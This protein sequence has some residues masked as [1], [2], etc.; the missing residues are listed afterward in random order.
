[1]N[2]NTNH[3]TSQN[4]MKKKTPRNARQPTTNKGTKSAQE[5]AHPERQ[6]S[7]RL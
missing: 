3:A 4:K 5:N 7:Q 2:D 6:Y 1:M